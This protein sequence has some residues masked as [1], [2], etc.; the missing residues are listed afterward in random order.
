M[1]AEA[2]WVEIRELVLRIPG[3]ERFEA[4]RLAEEV[5]RSLAEELARRP[6]QVARRLERLHVQVAAGTLPHELA[7]LI[8]RHIREGMS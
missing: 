5:A 8:A 4:R 3:L 7:R 1:R 2:P 6:A